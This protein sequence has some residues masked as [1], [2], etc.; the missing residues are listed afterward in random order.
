MRYPGDAMKTVE[1]DPKS[2][3]ADPHVVEMKNVCDRIA[4]VKPEETQTLFG[5]L[6]QMATLY[7]E[8]ALTQAMKSFKAAQIAAWVGTVLFFAVVL[9]ILVW[10][11][12]SSLRW[13]SVLPPAMIQ[14][15]SGLN[16]Y[17]YRKATQQFELFHV[18]LE[19][20]GRFLMANSVCANIEESAKRDQARMELVA[21][22][23]HAPMLPVQGLEHQ[24]SE[25]ARKSAKARE[26][27]KAATA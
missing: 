18:C 19:R 21:T 6:H 10:P 25:I 12:G 7:Y 17:M 13:L 11:E 26:V 4:H 8:G 27:S 9:W 20:M 16:F 23:A 5:Y 14:V 22:M 15:I 1:I 24:S 3:S 2:L